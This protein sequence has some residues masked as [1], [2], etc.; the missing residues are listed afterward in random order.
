MGA[1]SA[2]R[3]SGAPG[4]SDSR[5]LTPSRAA[6]PAVRPISVPVTSA[7]CSSPRAIRAAPSRTQ[8]WE[9]F[10]P[11]GVPTVEAEVALRRRA[12]ARPGSP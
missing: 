6:R 7:V 10:P 1:S 11:Y 4:A 5:R 9:R 8:A 2:M 12:N 3:R